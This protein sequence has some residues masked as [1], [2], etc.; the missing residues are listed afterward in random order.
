L[1]KSYAGGSHYSRQSQ[2]PNNHEN[3]FCFH[4]EPSYKCFYWLI[5]P[6]FTLTGWLA[7]G[8]FLAQDKV[9]FPVVKFQGQFPDGRLPAGLDLAKH[10]FD[11]R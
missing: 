4:A 11:C 7:Q 10:G 2:N 8:V 5:N 9:S 6:F 1:G 3:V